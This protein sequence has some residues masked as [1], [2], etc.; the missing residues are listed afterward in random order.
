MEGNE[1]GEDGNVAIEGSNVEM[2][3]PVESKHDI[4]KEKQKEEKAKEATTETKRKRSRAVVTQEED[5]KEI[6]F[7]KVS[8]AR[9]RLQHLL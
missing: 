6:N 2:D 4:E 8:K 5:L 9:H 3:A 1:S 7:R